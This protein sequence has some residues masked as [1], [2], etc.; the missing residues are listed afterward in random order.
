MIL[1]QMSNS[2]M[3]PATSKVIKTN[4]NKDHKEL[5]SITEK[6]SLPRSNMKS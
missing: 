3:P 5:T 2:S 4:D 6:I 1:T